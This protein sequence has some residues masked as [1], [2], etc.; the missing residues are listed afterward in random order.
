MGISIGAFENSRIVGVAAGFVNPAAFY[1]SLRKDKLGLV[2]AAAPALVFHPRRLARFARNYTR[3]HA[4]AAAKPERSTAELAS[5]GVHPSCGGQGI[6]ERLVRQF[7]A[8][9]RDRG[10]VQVTL[11]TDA[12]ANEQVNRFYQKLGFRLVACNE[13]QPGRYLNYYVIDVV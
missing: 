6:G 8:A 3:T 9:A 11:T 4:M 2:L 7:V 10:A 5:L 1:D 12:N 13:S